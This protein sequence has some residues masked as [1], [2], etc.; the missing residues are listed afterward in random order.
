VKV[1][2]LRHWRHA[3]ADWFRGMDARC[4]PTDAP[5]ENTPHCHW[6]IVSDARHWVCGYAG[7]YVKKGV[8]HFYRAG[9]KSWSRGKGCHAALIKA[10]IAWCRRKGIKRIKT[11]ASPDN[12]VSIRNLKR[13]GFKSRTVG[14]W[15]RLW[16]VL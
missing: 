11:Y 14:G 16:R 13:H 5:F 12:A 7:L 4:F 6:W 15:V 10:R 2:K 3:D 1:Q 9:V 8:A